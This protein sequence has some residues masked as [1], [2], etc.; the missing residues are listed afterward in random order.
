MVQDEPQNV[1]EHLNSLLA[2]GMVLQETWLDENGQ[3]TSDP[4]KAMRP[5]LIDV[6]FEL[7]GQQYQIV[8][9]KPVTWVYKAVSL[10]RSAGAIWKHE[11]SPM[12]A[13]VRPDPADVFELCCPMMM[14]GAFA[15]ENLLKGLCI[16]RASSAE[17]THGLRALWSNAGL[18]RSAPTSLDKLGCYI[19]TWG[20][21][22][23]PTQ[24]TLRRLLG[25]QIDW[26]KFSFASSDWTEVQSLCSYLH[27]EYQT[28]NL[29][30][31][32]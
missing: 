9:S 14:L 4:A 20:R 16:E 15:V 6:N 11:L 8:A 17:L 32:P 7:D 31:L 18:T 22:P 28:A 10:L 26:Q 24:A 13:G 19:T 2:S 23:A 1:E 21:Y 5:K 12:M 29:P 25:E 30:E 27:S 3:F